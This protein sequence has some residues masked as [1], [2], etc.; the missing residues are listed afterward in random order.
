[1]N[2]LKNVLASRTGFYKSYIKNI[3]RVAVRSTGH[4]EGWLEV[5]YSFTYKNKKY[6]CEQHLVGGKYSAKYEYITK[7][8]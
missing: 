8:V 2:E 1:M 3:K 5:D 6:I 7:E 4:A